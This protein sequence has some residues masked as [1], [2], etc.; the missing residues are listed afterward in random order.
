MSDR[1]SMDDNKI[2]FG[3]LEFT[4]TV[5]RLISAYRFRNQGR[6]PEAVVIPIITKVAGIAVEYVPSSYADPVVEEP[7]ETLPEK[8]VA[9]STPVGEPEEEL[10]DSQPE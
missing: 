8:E 2:T 1:T 5:R 9:D 7:E 10:N 4:T 6:D 3:D